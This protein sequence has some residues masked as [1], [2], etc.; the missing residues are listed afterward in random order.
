VAES[1]RPFEVVQDKGFQT[2]MKTGRPEYYLPSPSTVARDVRLVFKC[3]RERIAK[4]IMVSIDF[5][6]IQPNEN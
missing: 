4:M 1:L 3:T 5:F 2:L 6:L